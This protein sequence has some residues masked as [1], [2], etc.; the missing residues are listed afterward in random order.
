MA[1]MRAEDLLTLSDLM[2]AGKLTPVLDKRYPLGE[3]PAAIAYCETGCAR[4]KII[5]A[6]D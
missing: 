3:V 4:G 1:V 5:I 6:V 2:R